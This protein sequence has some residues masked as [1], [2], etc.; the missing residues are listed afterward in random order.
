MTVALVMSHPAMAG[1]KNSDLDE[2][3]T[4]SRYCFLLHSFSY[5]SIL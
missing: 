5:R 4:L 2:V 1:Y 3:S